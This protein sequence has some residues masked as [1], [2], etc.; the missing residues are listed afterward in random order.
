MPD[1]LPN[2]LGNQS[3]KPSHLSL[4][5]ERLRQVN[6]TAV[7]GQFA[8]GIVHDFNHVL[9]VI[10]GY[11]ELLLADPSES[12]AARERLLQI[13]KAVDHGVSLTRQLLVFVRKETL[14][15]IPL[16]LNNLIEELHGSLRGLLAE[17][18]E[19]LVVLGS[20][21]C[22]V[23]LDPGQLQQVVMNLVVNARD[24][25]PNGGRLTIETAAVDFDEPQAKQMGLQPGR[26]AMVDVTD[27]G[28]GMDPPTRSRIFEPFFTTKEAEEGT[29][30][31]LANVHEI[32]VRSGGHVMVD[33]EPGRG[34]T[35]Q[36]F[37]PCV[38]GKCT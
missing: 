1:H 12:D 29:G 28:S 4:C 9:N 15:P 38:T 30:L 7:L 17:S 36:V 6:K 22:P 13:R 10:C 20:D 37:L 5:E 33:S 35:F 26:Y 31:G 25:M 21:V 11:N 14:N 27:T 19:L 16:D 32:L 18:I 24:A 8:A 3:P 34:S 23:R 2:G